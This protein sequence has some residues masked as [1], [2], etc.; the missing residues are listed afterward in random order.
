MDHEQ[1]Q[2]SPE[3]MDKKLKLERRHCQYHPSLSLPPLPRTSAADNPPPSPELITSLISSLSSIS[4]PVESH[5][6]H[7]PSATDQSYAK[8]SSA[9]IG[10]SD[11]VGVGQSPTSPLGSNSRLLH[12]DSAFTPTFRGSRAVSSSIKSLASS[13]YPE[14]KPE[15]QPMSRASTDLFA[16]PVDHLESTSVDPPVHDI[17]EQP[18]RSIGVLSASSGDPFQRDRE[19]PDR[20]RERSSYGSLR[21]HHGGPH[22]NGDLHPLR[23]IRRRRSLAVSPGD[24]SPGSGTGAHS[25]VKI[26][27]RE[28]SL[29]HSRSP[30]ARKA[31][32]DRHS[33][34]SSRSSTVEARDNRKA[35]I[36][37]G[38]EA[39]QIKRRIQ[40]VKRQQQRIKSEYEQASPSPTPEKE[41]TTVSER[42]RRRHSRVRSGIIDWEP[43]LENAA[44]AEESAP[45]PSV[46]T[47]KSRTKDGT[48]IVPSPVG[49]D[50][51][52]RKSSICTLDRSMSQSGSKR[53]HKRIQSGSGPS[54]GASVS[55]ERPSTTDSVKAVVSARLSSLRLTQKV[56]HPTT[57]RIIAFSE[58]GDPNGHVVLCCLG[59]GVTRYLMAFYDELAQSLHL[60][61]ITLDRPGIGES[62]PFVDEVGAPLTWPGKPSHLAVCIPYC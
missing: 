5:F 3:D 60:R 2:S 28:S 45:S 25:P 16:A 37:D 23:S 36:E 27:S 41:K 55:E 48:A 40:E 31:R 46:M 10:D 57:G 42:P 18:P 6:D 54:S 56:A 17:P 4:I 50:R 59:M 24:K 34:Y 52:A 30:A 35:A 19:S 21:D 49:R 26:P 15:Q 51:L 58:V 11:H 29:R 1:Q 13:S 12:P 53:D 38:S 43:L 33:R 47:G 8:L 7:G 39:E 62:G 32:S 61:L 9:D 22:S 14:Q 20:L 44:A